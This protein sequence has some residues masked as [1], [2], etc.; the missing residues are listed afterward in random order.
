LSNLGR[1]EPDASICAEVFPVNDIARIQE[2]LGRLALD[3]VRIDLD[4]FIEA[5]DLVGSSQALGHGLS[6]AT[7]RSAGEWAEMARLLKPFRD[8]AVERIAAIR[9]ELAESD[10]DLVP[11]EAA[12]PGCRE[13]HVDLLSIEDDSVLCATCG[14]RYQLPGGDA[15]S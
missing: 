9:E 8:H 10:E 1:L 6:I 14:R 12:C 4:G 2:Q 7:M 13:R 5:S 3:A 15:D 11:Q